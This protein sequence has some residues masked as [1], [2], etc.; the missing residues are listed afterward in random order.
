MPLI[1]QYDI[2]GIPPKPIKI[3]FRKFEFEGDA[4][5]TC[6]RLEIYLKFLMAIFIEEMTTRHVHFV[7]R[8]SYADDM[9]LVEKEYYHHSRTIPY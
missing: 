3:N 7:E 4:K 1:D 9:T 5:R 6:F 2:S 8:I